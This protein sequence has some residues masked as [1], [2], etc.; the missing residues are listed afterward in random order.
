V[1]SGCSRY[2]ESVVVRARFSSNL[3]YMTRRSFA[4]ILGASATWAQKSVGQRSVSQPSLGEI[5]RFYDPVTENIV[6][7]LTDPRTNSRLPALQNRFVSARNHF[8]IFSSDRTGRMAPFHL[9]LRT[10]ALRQLAHPEQ[11]DPHSLCMDERERWLYFIDGQSLLEVELRNLKQRTVT[12]G[13]TAFAMGA[14]G[15]DLAVIK[16]GRVE[17]L[18]AGMTAPVA[19]NAAG[20]IVRPGE[21]GCAFWREGASK[22]MEFWYAPFASAD[23][24]PK[25]LASGAVVNP[26]WAPGGES[27]LFLREIVI[28][29]AE[30][31]ALPTKTADIHEVAIQSGVDGRIAPTSQFAAFSPNGNGT[32][33]VGASRSRAQPTVLLLLRATGREFTLCEHKA[34]DAAAASPVF[35]PNS[36][37]VYFQS[38]REGKWA[39]YSV[40]V[41]RLIEPTNI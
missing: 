23:G 33:F 8:L 35:S 31:G 37:R 3:T 4:A 9:D 27:L 30:A 41:E 13:V 7:R 17:R 32:V 24:Q 21:T 10:G 26:V 18:A 14:S 19:D 34:S 11:L 22:G 5:R 20:A 16:D 29:P 38:D 25:L 1:P 40:N 6:A 28:P 2:S 12:E 39:L 36:Q 15:A